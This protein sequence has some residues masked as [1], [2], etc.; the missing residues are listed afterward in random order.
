MKIIVCISPNISDFQSCS[1]SFFDLALARA[2]T[3][4]ISEEVGFEKPD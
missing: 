4:I 2:Q 3:V 1:D